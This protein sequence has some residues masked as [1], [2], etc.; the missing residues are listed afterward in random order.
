MK[1]DPEEFIVDIKNPRKRE[2]QEAPGYFI[3]ENGLVWSSKSEK[4][5]SLKWR[6]GR[7]ENDKDR[8]FTDRGDYLKVCIGRKIGERY[9]HRLLAQAFIPN[10][11]NYPYV[12]HINSIKH[13]NRL[14]NLRWCTPI[15]NALYEY[16]EGYRQ[17]SVL[18]TEA[19]HRISKA[20]T[21]WHKHNDVHNCARI[22]CLTQFGEYVTTYKSLAECARELNIPAAH[23]Q[24]AVW[25]NKTNTALG[26]GGNGMDK[27]SNSYRFMYEEEYLD[28]KDKWKIPK[29]FIRLE[30]LMDK[31][32]YNFETQS[33]INAWTYLPVNPCKSNPRY[34][35]K[36][37]MLSTYT[38]RAYTVQGIEKMKR[39]NNGI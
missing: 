35:S 23:L 27:K 29:G 1:A 19:K 20:V 38:N 36:R 16:K 32:L 8:S 6:Y 21:E 11:N 10:P 24:Q 39:I 15:Q 33:V 22:V 9:I 30:G 18:G 7:R 26:T 2:I 4:Y 31:Y 17:P 25:R 13:D 3:Y 34:K 12:D 28:N 37:F 14:E 5:L